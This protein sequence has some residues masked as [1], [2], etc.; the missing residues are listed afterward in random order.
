M[1]IEVLEQTYKCGCNR[2]LG[3]LEEEGIL[4]RLNMIIEW[5]FCKFPVQEV[6]TGKMITKKEKVTKEDGTEEEQDIEVEEVILEE[7]KKFLGDEPEL[8]PGN[9]FMFRGQVIAVDSEDRL[10]L[11]ISETGAFALDRIYKEHIE[12]EIEMTFNNYEINDVT[13]EVIE[14]A[15]NI[16]GDY[17][18]EFTVPYMLYSIWKDKFLTGRGFLKKGLLLHATLDSEDFIFPLDFIMSDWSV[19]YKSSQLLDEKMAE[20]AILELLSGFYEKY[21]RIVEERK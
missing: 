4:L 5:K 15:S 7:N 19:T 10:V 2:G 17:D 6:K 8:K 16:P 13:Y 20:R 14:S 11:V 21:P 9:V 3:A 1:I 18:T 12:P